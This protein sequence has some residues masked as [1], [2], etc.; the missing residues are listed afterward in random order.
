MV[1]ASQT[2]QGECDSS[3]SYASPVLGIGYYGPLADRYYS[4]S[5]GSFQ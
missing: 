3:R 2:R 4:Y 1:F 5:G